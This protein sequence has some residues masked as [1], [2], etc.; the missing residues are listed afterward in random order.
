MKLDLNDLDSMSKNMLYGYI[1]IPLS[2]ISYDVHTKVFSCAVY[3]ILNSICSC[4]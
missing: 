4:T 1:I 3:S 2:S